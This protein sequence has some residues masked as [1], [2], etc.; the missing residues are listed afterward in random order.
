MKWEESTPEKLL[1]E[2][3]FKLENQ[4]THSVLT[5]E[6][7]QWTR[8]QEL[9]EVFW[10]KTLKIH[11]KNIHDAFMWCS[12]KAYSHLPGNRTTGREHM[13][14]FFYKTFRNCSWSGWSNMPGHSMHRLRVSEGQMLLE[15]WL[16]S[17]RGD[18][19]GSVVFT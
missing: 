11:Q 19:N 4:E 2:T 3:V 10:K 17:I 8:V 7:I 15:C 14:T 13:S 6:P 16:L 12:W 5:T 9:S 1:N 18:F